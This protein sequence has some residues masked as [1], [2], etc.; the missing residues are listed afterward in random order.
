[1][2]G[3]TRESVVE[4]AISSQWVC[5]CDTGICTKRREGPDIDELS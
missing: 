4:P 1:M 2:D 3:V 5:A